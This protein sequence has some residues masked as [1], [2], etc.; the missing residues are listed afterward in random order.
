MNDLCL[1]CSICA[2]FLSSSFTVSIN[3]LFLNRILSAML[4]SIFFILFF[5]LV[6]SCTP[7]TN[8]VSKSVFPIYPLS[9]Y[10][11]P[12]IFLKKASCLSGSLSS[13]PP[14]VSMKFSISPLS[15]IIKCSLKP[16]NHPIEHFPRAASPSNVLWIWIRWLRQTRKGVESAKLIPVHCPKSTCLMNIVNGRRISFS[17]STKRL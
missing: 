9:A 7:L 6:T 16:K 11:F 5:T 3:A 4:I 8:R 14:G 1:E 10:S 13:T 17:N 2:I 15:L 12:L